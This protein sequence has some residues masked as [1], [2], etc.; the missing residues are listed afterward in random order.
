MDASRKDVAKA[1]SVRGHRFAGLSVAA[2]LAIGFGVLLVF[3]VLVGIVGVGG[4]HRLAGSV[5]DIVL[6]NNAK[7]A[8]AQAMNSA[9]G[10]QEKGLLYLVLATSGKER[11]GA[12]SKMKFQASQYQDSIKGLQDLFAQ[13]PPSASEKDIVA[14][15][16]EHEKTVSSLI[17][18]TVALANDRKAE[19]V[20]KMLRDSVG[21]ALR[22]WTVDIEELVS[23]EQRLNDAAVTEAQKDYTWARAFAIASIVL[24]MLVGAV[25]ALLIARSLRREL[26]GEPAYAAEI[27]AKIANGDLDVHVQTRPG[28]SGSLLAAMKE[29]SEKLA[30]IVTNVR[31]ASDSV[32]SA[33][34]QISTGNSDLSQ[35]TQEQASALEETASSME[36]MTSTVKQS[37]DNA[38][39]ANQLAASARDQA[40]KGGDVVSKAVSAMGEINDA[41]KKI[42]DIIGVINEIA[43]QTNLLALNAAVEAARAGEQGR[44]FAVVATEVR[45]LA[46]RSATAAKEIKELISDSVDKVK[47]GTSLVDESGKTLSEIVAGVKKVSDI[48]AEIAAASQEQSAG[49]DQVN[50]AVMQMD[51]ATQQNAALVEEAA[52]ASKSMEEQAGHLN[53]AVSFFK[54]GEGA[55]AAG[56]G[57]A[58]AAD[59]AGQAKPAALRAKI[60]VVAGGREKGNG[61]AEPE[62]KK[63]VRLVPPAKAGLHAMPSHPGAKKIASVERE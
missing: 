15:I 41:S 19:T 36:E 48:I 39:Q 1:K 25:F 33:A 32:G 27:A 23:I 3:I 20:L 11:E 10:D 60:S 46:Q 37:A 53:E 28:D 57:R 8:Y 5:N 18:K 63:P 13:A 52:A 6:Y 9:L 59:G 40:E 45:N 29:M 21:P 12:Q 4:M 42:A 31:L 47:V 51:E 35:R 62:G 22:D 55:S 44:G 43:F 50:K 54:T 16:L 38:R 49:I 2:R 61:H 14:K 30:A 24:A 26:G 58:G 7:L 56:A 17:A 34:K